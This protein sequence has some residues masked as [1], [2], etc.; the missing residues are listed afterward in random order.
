MK[1]HAVVIAALLSVAT[2][3]AQTPAHNSAAHN[4]SLLQQARQA[5]VSAEALEAQLNEKSPAERTRSLYLKVI[6]AYQRVYLITPHTGYADNALMTIARLYEEI[7]EKAPAMQTL[8]FLIR[9]YP[10]TPFKETAEKDLARL[11]G[12]PEK[13]TGAV[14]NVRYWETQNSVRVVIDVTG[15]IA[16]K[17]GEA[18]SPDRVFIDI[19]PARLNSLLA[20]KQWPV[21]SDLLD[22]IRIGQYDASTVRVVL[23]V[24]AIG[25]TTSFLLKDPDR[26]VVDVMAKETAAVSAQPVL[27]AVTAPPPVP[28]PANAT[29]KP[30]PKPPDT[31][32]PD[33]ETK[34]IT[35]AKPPNP[36]PRSPIPR[37]G[38]K[39]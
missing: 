20:G 30:A 25:Q 33:A 21:K 2:L 36:R 27:A 1:I 35:P 9:E 24:G 17:Q 22:Q 34:V 8:S 5:F 16:F 37:L 26:L 11:Q 4:S 14:E 13:K 23:H 10:G 18:R 7:E 6:K 15:E 28:S 19:S 38:P 39:P 32:P 31:K 29:T 12:V 3:A